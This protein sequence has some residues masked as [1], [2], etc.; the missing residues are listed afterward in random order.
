MQVNLKITTFM[1]PTI[2]LSSQTKPKSK[3]ITALSRIEGRLPTYFMETTRKI[4]TR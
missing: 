1:E 2:K 4:Q 3:E